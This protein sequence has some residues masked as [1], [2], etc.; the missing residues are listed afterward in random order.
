[1]MKCSLRDVKVVPTRLP[2]TCSGGCQ[3]ATTKVEPRGQEEEF[4][5]LVA[6]PRRSVALGGLQQRAGMLVGRDDDDDGSRC[7]FV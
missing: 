3:L 2:C 7:A 6:P 5:Q 4:D 1:M